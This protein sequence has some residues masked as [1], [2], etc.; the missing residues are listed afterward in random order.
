[1]NRLY[2]RLAVSS[3]LALGVAGLAAPAALA[4][5]D[6][7]A[8]DTVLALAVAQCQP[9][10]VNPLSLEELAPVVLGES[11]VDVV[12]GEL[13]AHVVR[14]QVA[15]SA[16][17][18]VGVLHRDALLAQV[19][20]EGVATVGGTET[21]IEVGNMGKSS[22]ID[23]TVE[24]VL[25]G[26]LVPIE[27]VTEDPA[28]AI[29]LVRKSRETVSIA[30]TRAEK[31]AAARLLKKQTKAAADLLRKQQHAHGKHADQALAA[32]QRQ[33]DKRIAVAQK[34][35]EK[36]ITPRTVTRPVGVDYSVSGTVARADS[37]G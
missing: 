13:T 1:M 29:T 34:A 27:E 8:S 36:A 9:D 23:P 15:G 20:Y 32:A 30:V 3:V 5:S 26:S 21:E 16:E 31:D 33:Y 22:P 7:L 25:P 14:I 10:P 11:D 12:P 4:T 6:P 28:F 17:C 18:T 19:A 24:V 2:G 35:Y 37:L